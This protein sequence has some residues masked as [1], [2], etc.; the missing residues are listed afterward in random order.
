MIRGL[1][2][3]I[4]KNPSKHMYYLKSHKIKFDVENEKW[5]EDETFDQPARGGSECNTNNP[6]VK[7]IPATDDHLKM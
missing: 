2:T 4:G 5:T 7:P 1:V 3:S 6:A